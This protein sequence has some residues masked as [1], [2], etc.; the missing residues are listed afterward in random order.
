MDNNS[1]LL[2]NQNIFFGVPLIF[3][4]FIFVMFFSLL[5]SGQRKKTYGNRLPGQ[6]PGVR[7][8]RYSNRMGTPINMQSRDINVDISP[9]PMNM[10]TGIYNDQTVAQ[11]FSAPPDTSYSVPIDIPDSGM[12][13]AAVG[14][15]DSVV[16][17]IDTS[18]FSN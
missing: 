7:T 4:L 6:K 18:S 14:A 1:S 5:L 17:G 8:R 3:G 2:F 15:V 16:I 10:D 12:V 13:D 11:T 9:I